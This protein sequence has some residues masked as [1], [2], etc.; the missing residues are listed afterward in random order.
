M[1]SVLQGLGGMART[2]RPARS[3]V[4]AHAPAGRHRF[5]Q[6]GEV[7]VVR[8]SLPRADGRETPRQSEPASPGLSHER[9]ARQSAERLHQEVTATLHGVQTRLG[10]AEMALQEAQRQLLARDERIRGLGASLIA[11]SQ[12]RDAALQAR[13]EAEHRCAALQG[14]LDAA[15]AQRQGD[16]RPEQAEAAM[17]GGLQGAAHGEDPEPVKWWR[18]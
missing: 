3:G 1:R 14:R 18:D 7:P 16:Q 4:Q 10:H 2:A 6:D 12:D 15:S 17:A 11:C 13:D 9:L 5:V 8:L